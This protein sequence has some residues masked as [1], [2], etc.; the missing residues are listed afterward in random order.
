[1]CDVKYILRKIIRF[2]ARFK[3]L[4]NVKRKDVNPFMSVAEDL[5]SSWPK[6]LI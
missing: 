3:I 5:D 2:A 1:M 6:G 4:E